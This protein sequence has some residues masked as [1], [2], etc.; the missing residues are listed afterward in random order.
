MALTH[1]DWNEIHNAIRK[2][3][4]DTGEAFV[5]GVVIKSDA[6]NKVIYL[7]E[8]GDTP[9]P[10]VAHHYQVKYLAR[11]DS[12]R[13]IILKTLAYSADVEVLVPRIG[14]IVLVAQHLGTR[15]LP[16]CLG[17]IMSRNFVQVD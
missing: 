15:A 1:G 14:D 7:K 12:G 16:K 13:K 4:A 2:G 10:I 8:F 5:Q 17:V 9:I 3:V 11:D 6:I